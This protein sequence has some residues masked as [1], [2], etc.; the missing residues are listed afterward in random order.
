MKITKEI[1]RG[2]DVVYR[3]ERGQ[4]HREDGPSIEWTSGDVSYHLYGAYLSE[5]EFLK[6][7]LL[8]LMK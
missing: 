4:L 5:Q 8:N 2:G 1:T 6:Q 3:N 7:K